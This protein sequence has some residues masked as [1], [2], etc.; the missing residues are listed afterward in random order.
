MC[1]VLRHSRSRAGTPAAGALFAGQWQVMMWRKQADSSGCCGPAGCGL[2][3][4]RAGACG[5]T[6]ALRREPGRGPA[7]LSTVT[8]TRGE[9]VKRKEVLSVSLRP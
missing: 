5:G 8:P 6:D 1:Q 7:R 4:M 3:V 2:S 9:E